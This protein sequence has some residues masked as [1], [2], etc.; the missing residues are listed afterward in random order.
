[1]QQIPGTMLKIICVLIA[2]ENVSIEEVLPQSVT[3]AM[4]TYRAIVNFHGNML[5]TLYQGQLD[6][7][8]NKK[9]AYATNLWHQAIA[10][11]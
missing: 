5:Y 3:G 8:K 10:V 6:D 9:S 2:R 7:S 4:S 1:M 11:T